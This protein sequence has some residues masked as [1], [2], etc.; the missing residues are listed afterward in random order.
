M[1]LYC[2]S[3][4]LLGVILLA[5][6]AAADSKPDAAPKLT[7]EARVAI[8][9]A[10]GSE[11]AFAR[12]TFPQGRKGLSLKDGVISPGP[13]ELQTLVASFGPAV[14]PGDRA[15]ITDIKFKDRSVLFEI[16]GG[17]VKKKKWY[18]R[19]QVSGMGGTVSPGQQQPD[20]NANMHGSYVELM[21]D[22][23]VPDLTP[24]QV[25]ELLTPVLNF[26]A[27]SAAEAY[28]DTVPPK[29][30]DA[31]KN[32][33]VLVGMNREM[34]TYA[35]GRPPQKVREKDEKGAEYEEWIYGQPPREME[36]VR[37]VGDEV[38]RLEIMQVDGEKVVKTEKEVD[39]K[40]PQPALAEQQPQHPAG[41]QP[42][43]AGKPTLRR[44]GEE[45]P[46]SDT[47]PG[48]TPLPP[49]PRPT[50]SDPGSPPK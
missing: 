3:A 28:M 6:F 30:R 16:N 41:D 10:L 21:F 23:Y 8:I 17:P 13:Q 36:F 37:F 14:K 15:R 24:D 2:T 38:V 12:T 32:H 40:P 26:S 9:R 27:K 44:P 4:A 43:P 22:K 42:A 50:S 11:L 18:E 25:K 34:V 35:K 39:I 31:I 5:V 46:P 29:V 48:R 20:D 47:S 19:I 7:V 1:K 45:A 49:P 33:Q